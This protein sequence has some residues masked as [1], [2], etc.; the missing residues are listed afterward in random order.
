MPSASPGSLLI[1]ASTH[2]A[3]VTGRLL[4]QDAK[5]GVGFPFSALP[6]CPVKHPRAPPPEAGAPSEP[7]TC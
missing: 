7:H 6:P 4:S 3:R 2:G 1:W 5:A